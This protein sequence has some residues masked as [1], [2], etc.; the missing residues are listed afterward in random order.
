[1]QV[2]TIQLGA[3]HGKRLSPQVQVKQIVV[4]QFHQVCQGLRLPLCQSG[5]EPREE[6]FNE[7]IILKQTPATPP[8]EFTQASFINQLVQNSRHW[9]GSQTVRRTIISLILPIALVGLR[10]LGQTST[11]FMMVWQRNKR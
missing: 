10:P 7:Q 2:I 6:A 3:H 1:M 11:Q 9:A 8:A 5:L 4:A